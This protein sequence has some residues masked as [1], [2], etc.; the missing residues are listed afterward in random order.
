[1]EKDTDTVN[2]GRACGRP[3][4]DRS[5]GADDTTI[6]SS[7]TWHTARAVRRYPSDQRFRDQRRVESAFPTLCRTRTDMRTSTPSRWDDRG[8]S[9]DVATG[10]RSGQSRTTSARAVTVATDWAT[11]VTT[12]SVNHT[13]SYMSGSGPICPAFTK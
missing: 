2:N 10:V 6:G 13:G 3:C 7:G 12:F 9:D 5:G 11:K 8:H 1:M 4:S